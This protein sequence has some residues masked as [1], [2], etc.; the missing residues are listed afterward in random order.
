MTSPDS[1]AASLRTTTIFLP[2]GASE[3]RVLRHGSNVVCL[4]GEIELVQT[5]AEQGEYTAAW[6][7]P[8]ERLR[9]GECRTIEFSG[10][11]VVRAQCDARVVYLRAQPVLQRVWR[12]GVQAFEKW[13]MILFI[14]RGVEQSGSSSGS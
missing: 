1:T 12:A 10:P 14:R 4:A 3:R 7:L 8:S 11:V 9:E 2:A 5:C 13:V 6:P